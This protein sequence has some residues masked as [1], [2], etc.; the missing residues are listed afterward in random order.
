VNNVI[1]SINIPTYNRAKFLP[2]L[3]DSLAADIR[4]LGPVVE[5]NI[6]DNASTDNTQAVVGEISKTLTL[7]YQ[8]NPENIG[9]LAN[10]HRAHRVGCGQYVWVIGDDDYLRPGQLKRIVGELR[11]SPGVVLLS[12]E[13]HTAAGRVVGRTE[14]GNSDIRL[15]KDSPEFNISMIDNFIGFISV[16]IMKREW[17][18]RYPEDIYDDLDKRGELA[19]ATICY[20]AIAGG[21]DILCLAGAPLV[22][23]VDNGYLSHESWRFVCVLYCM[24]LPKKLVELGLKADDVYPAFKRRVIKECLRRLLSEKYR[25]HKSQIVLADELTQTALGRMHVVLRLVDIIPAAAVRF[26]YNLFYSSRK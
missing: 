5:I 3:L 7:N 14:F 2:I 11:R 13:R 22:Q 25:G 8:R 16:N 17:V 15:T 19:H 23:L 12:S 4:E 26:V 18:D 1:L 6:I 10:I 21:E 9:G 24:N 20:A